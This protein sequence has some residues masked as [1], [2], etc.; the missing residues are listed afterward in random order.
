[1]AS[2]PESVDALAIIEGWGWDH[3]D[4]RF[5]FHVPVMVPISEAINRLAMEGHH[6]PAGAMLMLLGE[7]KLQATG[8]YRWK[9]YL[10][11]H[12][13]REG[14]GPIPAHRWVVLR[15]GCDANKGLRPNEGAFQFIDADWN[16]GK[17]PRAD[18]SWQ[19]DCFSTAQ[20]SGGDWLDEGYFEES[21]S[22]TDIE[23]RPAEANC[24]SFQIDASEGGGAKSNRGGAPA[25]YDW[26]RAVAAVV[27]QWADDG[28]WHPD[29]QADV[30][31]RLSAWFAE[32][33]QYPSDSLLKERARWLF[34]EFQ[35]RRDEADNVA[36]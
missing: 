13:A 24:G 27:F 28:S 4:P 36:T 2:T 6:D 18:W 25:K 34:A 15:Q 10:D 9:K 22:V 20:V 5:E 3:A 32:H 1:M 17:E 26:E 31:K 19:N 16:G 11:G 12:F 35:R 23:V 21:Y 7:G 14:T 33:D 29:I 30:K 8:H